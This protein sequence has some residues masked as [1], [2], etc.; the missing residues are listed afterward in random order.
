MCLLRVGQREEA[1][2]LLMHA[3]QVFQ[4]QIPNHPW[5]AQ[6]RELLD[7]VAAPADE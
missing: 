3:M 4:A 2:G 5:L 7:D 1:I 6:V